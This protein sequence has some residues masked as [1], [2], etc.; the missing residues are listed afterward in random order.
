VPFLLERIVGDESN[1]QADRL[2]PVAAAQSALL[3]TVW[4]VLAPL[5]KQESR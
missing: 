1:F 4:P 2:H 5:L 3:E